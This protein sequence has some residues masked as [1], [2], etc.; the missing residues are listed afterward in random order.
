MCVRVFESV[1]PSGR[2]RSYATWHQITTSTFR[3]AFEHYAYEISSHTSFRLCV[4]HRWRLNRVGAGFMGRSRRLGRENGLRPV[5]D[6]P[7]AKFCGT[8]HARLLVERSS[9]VW[10][11]L[12]ETASAIRD[13]DAVH[14]GSTDPLS[15][16]PRTCLTICRRW[17]GNAA[18]QVIL[19]T[20]WD[21][22]L[23]VAGGTGVRLMD[24]VA[25]TGELRIRNHGWDFGGTTTDLSAG[26]AWRLPSF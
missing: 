6:R 24:R 10:W 5:W 20:D 16:E 25:V 9:R 14:A 1:W 18:R 11:R 13:V 17:T 3:K 4:C 15:L 7:H 12:R 23:S 2:I 22:T 19:H 8:G 21:P 26:L